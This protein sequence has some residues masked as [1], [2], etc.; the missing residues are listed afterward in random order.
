MRL[1][2]RSA[3]MF[4]AILV[5]AVLTAS[6]RPGGAAQGQGASDA[7]S[8]M[9]AHYGRALDV[10]AAVIRGDLRATSEAAAWLADN[11]GLSPLPSGGQP[12]VDTIRTGARKVAGSKDLAMAAAATSTM[13]AACGGCHQAAKVMPAAP[14]REPAKVGGIVGSMVQHQRAAEQMLQGLVVPS[15]SMWRDGARGFKDAEFHP[16]DLPVNTSARRQMVATEKRL[17]QLAADAIEIGDADARA[18]TYG[19]ILAA[20]ADCHRQ[21]PKIWGPGRG[22]GR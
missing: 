13:L 7:T 14:V 1:L 12:F 5:S 18:R 17:Q 2:N 19:A 21:H 20:C 11:A 15:A 22:G 8:R 16:K 3:V 6:A 4:A 9:R 10:H